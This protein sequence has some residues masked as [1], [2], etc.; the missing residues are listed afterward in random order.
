ME[1]FLNDFKDFVNARLQ[2]PLFNMENTTEYKEK[3]NNYKL[4]YHNLKNKIKKEDVD[5]LEKLID[6]K[7]RIEDFY[8][9]ISYRT[10]FIDGIKM[11][12]SIKKENKK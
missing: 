3:I 8:I 9:N 5:L 4:H 2:Q 10:G 6:E 1:D 12:N 7:E 11:E